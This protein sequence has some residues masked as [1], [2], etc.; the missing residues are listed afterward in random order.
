MEKA[1]Q[2]AQQLF[3]RAVEPI[4]DLQLTDSTVKSKGI[5]LAQIMLDE[6]YTR[7]SDQS[8]NDFYCNVNNSL[9]ESD[10]IY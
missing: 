3:D 7:N 5:E 6:I 1:Q 10:I 8:K 4:M 2:L 9:N